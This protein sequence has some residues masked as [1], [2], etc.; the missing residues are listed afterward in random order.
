MALSFPASPTLN[1]TYTVGYKTWIWNGYAWDLQIANIISLT[2]NTI[3]LSGALNTA[4]A[5]IA[6]AF[7]QA[8][9]A[10]A[11]NIYLQGALNT[12]NTNASTNLAYLQGVST[13]QNVRLDYSNT[14]INIIQ[15]VDTTQ[16]TRITVIEG[17]DLSQNANIISLQTQANTLLPNTGSLITVNGSSQL[18]ISNTTASTSNTTGALVVKGGLGVSGNSY[19]SN[20]YTS[21]IYTTGGPATFSAE[22]G[23][24]TSSGYIGTSLY[25][26][27]TAN[28]TRSIGTQIQLNHY[29]GGW[30]SIGTSAGNTFYLGTTINN[31]QALQWGSANNYSNGFVV[32]PASS[33]LYVSN[34]STSAVNVA[35]GIVA[36][37]ITTANAVFTGGTIDNMVIGGTTQAA[38]SF[39][40]ITGQTEVLKGTGTNLIL[41]SN[42]F[43]TTWL[44]SSLTLSTGQTDPFGGSTATLI[45]P[46]TTGVNRWLYQ[47]LLLLNL[48]YTF[49]IYAKVGGL[50]Y[51]YLGKE[52]G[53]GVGSVWFNLSTGA[54]GTTTAGYTPT[55]TSIGS[56]W[57]RCSVTFIDTASNG[58]AIWGCADADNSIT[59]TTSGTN[60]IYI[61]GAQLEV[62]NTT[63]T[64]IPTTTTAIYG[65]PTLSFSGVAGLSLASNGSLYVS[66]AGTGS[67]AV[68]GNTF[69]SSSANS[70]STINTAFT[71]AGSAGVANSIYVGN[72]VGYAN[73]NNISV[74]YQFYNSATQ[75]YDLVFG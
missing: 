48:T 62:G 16:N 22:Y 46:T 56:G 34:T 36:N 27:T 9:T 7:A 66:P 54:V 4:N 23:D 26:G 43:G 53:T 59:A 44:K 8:N 42:T 52:S 2:A 24:S 25:F 40:T 45:Y 19:I 50:N 51:I 1:Q 18:V 5:N 58:Y 72:R 15:G 37:T 11:N 17:T 49:S 29:S 14:A 74:M 32:I 31:L 39:T 30:G 69:I 63:N 75:S 71:V 65:T 28:F 73:S 64:Y 61:Y 33:N 21:K 70:Y 3:Y 68:T 35:G 12:S 57:Y 41:Q 60:G 6:A 38:G 47:Q 67:L 20:A 10:A 13:S 55:I